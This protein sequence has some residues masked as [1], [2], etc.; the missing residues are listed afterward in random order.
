[1]YYASLCSQ[2]RIPLLTGFKRDTLY[3]I[4]LSFLY[5]AVHY[6]MARICTSLYG[7]LL[8]SVL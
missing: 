7:K 5:A 2:L 3:R 1:L 4:V 6:D 8:S